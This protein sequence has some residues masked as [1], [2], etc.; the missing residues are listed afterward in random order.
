MNNEQR[1][2]LLL[3]DTDNTVT[4]LRDLKSGMIMLM[5]DGGDEAAIALKQDI[6]FAHKFART[7][8]PKGGE[9]LKYGEI[10][11][12]ATLE[13]S[14]GDHVHIHNIESNRARAGLRC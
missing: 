14:P 9:V 8:I 2:F 10:I 1:D 4:A 12:I 5:P 6:P 11:G 3:E 7:H 13:I